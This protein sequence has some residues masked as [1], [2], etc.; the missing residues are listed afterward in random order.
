MLINQI[1][2]I[3]PFDL[4]AGEEALFLDTSGVPTDRSIPSRRASDN[5]SLKGSGQEM[6]TDGA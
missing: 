4:V 6:F 2:E 3:T 1:R 5:P